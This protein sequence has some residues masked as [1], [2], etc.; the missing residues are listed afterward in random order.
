MGRWKS[1]RV[2]LL[3]TIKNPTTDMEYSI[4]Y[5]LYKLTC[6]ELEVRGCSEMSAFHMSLVALV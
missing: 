1:F 5:T 3:Y 6:P 2:P 4:Y